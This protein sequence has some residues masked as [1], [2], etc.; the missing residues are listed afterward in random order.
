MR[1]GYRAWIAR[2][3]LAGAA[4]AVVFGTVGASLSGNASTPADALPSKYTANDMA[5]TGVES[6]L[7]HGEAVALR[8]P[9]LAKAS[10]CKAGISVGAAQRGPD[11]IA[12]E[13]RYYYDDACSTVA[14]TVLV[15]EAGR[16]LTTVVSTTYSTAGDRIAQRTTDY[17]T[18]NSGGTTSTRA[19]S[20]LTAGT[21]NSVVA[22]ANASWDQTRGGSLTASVA[23]IGDPQTSSVG[24]AVQT[25]GTVRTASDG[26]Q[27]VSA[28]SSGPMFRGPAGGLAVTLDPPYRIISAPQSR[29]GVESG[30]W[31]EAVDAAG[32]PVRLSVRNGALSQGLH[33]DV[34][35]QGG[36]FLGTI[37][38]A[39]GATL[40]RLNVDRFGDGTVT[41]ANGVSSAIADWH[42]T[43]STSV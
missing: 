22:L 19:D 23:R 17:R 12:Q 26:S 5:A 10:R 35:T 11:G 20:R 39:G 37:T 36:R 40:A 6:A 42:C 4:T 28:E 3:G 31:D 8:A 18:A 13:R 15:R 34:D 2:V 1:I 38:S 16:G 43:N 32:L 29:V 27:R 24:V 25:N 41:Y 30:R 33:L 21:T 9:R 14:R 7:A